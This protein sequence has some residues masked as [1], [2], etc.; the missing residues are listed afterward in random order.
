VKNLFV[1]TAFLACP[2]AAMAQPDL[3]GIWQAKADASS[4][5]EKF[6]VPP[7][8]I[9]Y[10]PDALA[11]RKENF[12]N[13]ETADTVK[14]CYLPG[15]P[16]INLLPMP[17]QIFQSGNYVAIVYQYAHTYRTIYLDGSQHLDGIDFWMGD[18]RGHWEK[19]ALVIDVTSF[20]DQT[21]LD[22]SGDYHSDALHVVERFTRTGPEAMTYEAT[23]DDPK[24][25]THSWKIRVPLQLNTAKNARL[26]EFECQ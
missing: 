18:S 1:V 5:L 2:I 11:K 26:M 22:A 9:P 17:F 13:R 19:D 7:G 6:I 25:F 10:R 20:N 4:D 24:T 21:W 8:K 23:I 3:Q 14:K 16:R 15:V 12:Q